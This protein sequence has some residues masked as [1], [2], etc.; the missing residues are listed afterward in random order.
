MRTDQRSCATAAAGFDL[1]PTP[2]RRR[3][4][5]GPAVS[6]LLLLILCLGPQS[7]IA[8][9]TGIRASIEE[10]EQD[11]DFDDGPREARI[12]RLEFEIEE[13]LETGSILGF[14]FGIFDVN[15]RSDDNNPSQNP[16]G[17][18]LD[19][20]LRHP[21]VINDRLSLFTR[22]DYR[23]SSGSDRDDN[24]IDWSEFGLELGLGLRV[25]HF[26]ITPFARAHYLDGDVDTDS[27]N[28][29]FEHDEPVSG[30]IRLDYFVEDT[31]FVRLILEGGERSGVYLTFAREY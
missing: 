29:T 21:F 4:S 19:L 14:G 16:D 30:G 24:E 20:F 18:Y 3:S 27:G 28:E 25:S 9:F 31:A 13:R 1:I 15:L 6:I 23:Y 10:T 17:E 22:F 11:W 7:S 8:D 5:T 12:T 26:R 2:I